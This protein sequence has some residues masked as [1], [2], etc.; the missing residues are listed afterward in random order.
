MFIDRTRYRYWMML[1]FLAFSVSFLVRSMFITVLFPLF[2]VAV[3]ERKAGGARVIALLS[4]AFILLL[5]L[6]T[7][8]AGLRTQFA[9][10]PSDA[11]FFEAGYAPQHIGDLLLWRSAAVPMFAASDTLL[12]FHE[13]LGGRH[14]WGATSTFL[15]AVFSMERVN[16]EV[17]VHAY[18]WGLND[19]GNSNAVFFTEGYVNFGA[20]GVGLY[21]LFVGQSLRWFRQSQDEAFKALWPVYSYLLFSGGLISHLISNGYLLM[22]FLAFFI[23]IEKKAPAVVP[24]AVPRSVFS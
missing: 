18:Q 17:L 14:L 10:G 19:L 12:V 5:V 23:K 3:H 2:Y 4:A 1:L 6:T 16:V 9:D 21:A 7:L 22:F 13:L 11:S 20:V 15:S 8:A 24:S